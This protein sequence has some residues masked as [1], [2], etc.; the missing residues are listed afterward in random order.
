VYKELDKIICALTKK[1]ADKL[2]TKKLFKLH[3]SQ[4]KKLHDMFVSIMS[5]ESDDAMFQKRALGRLLN[6]RFLCARC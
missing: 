6:F 1:L 4:Y 5:N 3:D 2:E